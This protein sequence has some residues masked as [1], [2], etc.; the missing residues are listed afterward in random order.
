MFFHRKLV[1]G[2]LCFG[3]S[4]TGIALVGAQA[5]TVD[6]VAPLRASFSIPSPQIQAPAAA[7]PVT[8]AQPAAA[9]PSPAAVRAAAPAAAEERAPARRSASGAADSELTCLARVILYEAGAE[10][11]AGQ[12][13]V[14]QVVMNRVRSPRFPNT[15]CAVIN[16][17][18]QFSAIRS[19]H[20]PRNARWNRALALAR[21]ARDGA[22][23]PGIGNALFFHAAHVPA[24][25]G[26]NRVARLGNHVFY[27]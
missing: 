16:Q 12:L 7:A 13:A 24:F 1:A 27:R 4:A 9:D 5:E 21:E 15:I 22:R 6:P 17:R 2:L 8:Q 3:L 11:R 20:P 23:A 18:G 14:A 26:R 19:F 25:R 10:S